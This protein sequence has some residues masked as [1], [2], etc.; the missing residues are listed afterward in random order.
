MAR[1]HANALAQNGMAQRHHLWTT[2]KKSHYFNRGFCQGKRKALRS[3]GAFNFWYEFNKGFYNT[4]LGD[5]SVL[6]FEA[7]KVSA[8]N[9]HFKL[10]KELRLP[11]N[12]HVTCNVIN[13]YSKGSSHWPYM[14][15]PI[16]GIPYLNKC[17]RVF[18]NGGACFSIGGGD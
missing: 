11:G 6:N 17:T 16:S 14:D 10:H 4:F 7:L 13:D 5:F 8:Q 1:T 18:V 2:L 3:G 9:L 15:T 12:L